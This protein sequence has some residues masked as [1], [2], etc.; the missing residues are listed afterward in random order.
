MCIRL[1]TLCACPT[2]MGYVRL[3]ILVMCVRLWTVAIYVVVFGHL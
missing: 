1:R 3:R 2:L